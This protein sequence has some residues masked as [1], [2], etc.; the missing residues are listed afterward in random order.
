MSTKL[1]KRFKNPSSPISPDGIYVNFPDYQVNTETQ[2][3]KQPL[4]H[5]MVIAV[6]ENTGN[7]R[8]S[9]YGRYNPG[10]SA[11]RV[12]VPNFHAADPGNPTQEELDAYAK[13]LDRAYGH[14]GGRT[15]VHYVPGADYGEMVDLMKSAESGD[16]KNGFYI[17][18]KYR[19]LDHNCGTYGVDLIK[20]AMPWYK[21]SGIGPYTVGTPSTVAPMWGGKGTYSAPGHKSKWMITKL[22][23]AATDGA[24]ASSK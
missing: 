23:N 4:G 5:G 19:L 3:G 22:F 13:Q 6:D 9:E 7:T 21:F 20:K 11:R 24:A 15:E 17:N 2:A 16:K 8:G 1:V 10:G 14:S 18:S 12:T